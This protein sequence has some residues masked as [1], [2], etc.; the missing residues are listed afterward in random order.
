MRYRVLGRTGLTPSYV[1]LSSLSTVELGPAE[2]DRFIEDAIARGVT[3][4]DVAPTYAGG[5]AER[6]FGRALPPH[7]DAIILA[8]KT[9]KRTG[10]EARQAL[11]ESLARLKTDHVD[12]YQLHGLDSAQDLDVALGPGGVGHRRAPRARGGGEGVRRPG[13]GG[14][15]RPRPRIDVRHGVEGGLGTVGAFRRRACPVWPRTGG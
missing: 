8:C 4:F 13:A 7:R 5:E 10:P 12:I 11:D 14:L 1:A 6:R 9:E 15:G 2:S 3:Y